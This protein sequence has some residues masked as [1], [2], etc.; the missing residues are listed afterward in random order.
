M[1]ATRD[2]LIRSMTHSTL[3]MATVDA[4]HNRRSP[5]ARPGMLEVNR[6]L[7]DTVQLLFDEKFTLDKAAASVEADL[8]QD[9]LQSAWP[10]AANGRE[11]RAF[12]NGLRLCDMTLALRSDVYAVA[13]AEYGVMNGWWQLVYDENITCLHPN[14][15]CM[16]HCTTYVD[17]YN[18][19]IGRR[20]K[21]KKEK[22]KVPFLSKFRLPDLFPERGI[23]IA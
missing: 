19:A 8:I 20:K 16:Q 14:P 2:W 12:G 6:A 15:S 23:A 3:R 21:R 1:S 10:Y 17:G 7:G 4:V 9:A 18:K 13:L 22:A 5:Q 11:I